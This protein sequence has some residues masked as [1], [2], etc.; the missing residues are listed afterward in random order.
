MVPSITGMATEHRIGTRRLRAQ[1]ADVL[2]R[3]GR[4]GTPY[5]VE[6][7]GEPVAVV[8]PLDL[9]RRLVAGGR[10]ASGGPEGSEGPPGGPYAALLALAGTMH[11][12]YSD[13]ARHKQRHLAQIFAGHGRRR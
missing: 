13:V 3:V 10:R 8:V 2:K 1:M 5:V 7:A 9:Y 6:R 4:S 12:A 11:A